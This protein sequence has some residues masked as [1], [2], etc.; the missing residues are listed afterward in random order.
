MGN[1]ILSS[2]HRGK[3]LCIFIKPFQG[4]VGYIRQFLDF[5]TFSAT[6]GN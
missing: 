6:F 3:P 4:Y 5:L 2:F 1:R